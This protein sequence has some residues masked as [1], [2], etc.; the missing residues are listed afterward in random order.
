M[1][2]DDIAFNEKMNALCY[3]RDDIFNHDYRH[4][5]P[6]AIAMEAKRWW[7]PEYFK[8]KDRYERFY[9]EEHHIPEGYLV[10]TREVYEPSSAYEEVRT[11]I[12]DKHQIAIPMKWFFKMN[13]MDLH[14]QWE[15][16][17]K[18]ILS[19]SPKVRL[20]PDLYRAMEIAYQLGIEEELK[21]WFYDLQVD[22]PKEYERR[23]QL[24]YEKEH[25]AIKEQRVC[26]NK[27]RVLKKD[28]GWNE[29]YEML[30]QRYIR[31]E[32]SM[33]MGFVKY[34]EK[35]GNLTQTGWILVLKSMVPGS[36]ANKIAILSEE[37][38]V[39]KQRVRDAHHAKLYESGR[40][41]FL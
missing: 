8:Y 10:V 2:T 20:A 3:D 11:M 26:E 15:V 7:W 32:L 18:N 25:I 34:L 12:I 38:V 5:S 37:L 16:I 35:H 31:S 27:I 19:L 36:L 41:S 9:A 24:L 4:H 21:K 6:I 29:K 22:N 13:D 1:R 23:V 28:E 14:R 30:Y 33:E 40:Y 17:R 39:L